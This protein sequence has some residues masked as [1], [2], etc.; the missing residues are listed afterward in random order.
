MGAHAF[1]AAVDAR[2]AS[3]PRLVRILDGEQPGTSQ[4]ELFGAAWSFVFGFWLLLPFD[5][6]GV[7]KAFAILNA[8]STEGLWA[9]VTVAFALW[10]A[11]AV[12]M[13]RALTRQK[14]TMVAVTLWSALGVLFLLGNPTS[15]GGALYALVAVFEAL[16]YRNQEDAA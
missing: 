3:I 12:L 4:P 8:I 10:R 11:D 15:P 14:L 6:F 7:T 9:L 16:S 1:G 13:N 2:K 5:T